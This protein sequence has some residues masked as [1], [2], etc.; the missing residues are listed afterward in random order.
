LY[1]QDARGIHDEELIA[2]VESRLAARLELIIAFT[3]LSHNFL[4]SS[5]PPKPDMIEQLPDGEPSVIRTIDGKIVRIPSRKEYD[6][7]WDEW[8]RRA[9]GRSL[10]GIDLT[11]G[12]RLDDSKYPIQKIFDL[13]AKYETEITDW[14]RN[15][16]LRVLNKLNKARAGGSASK[17]VLAID[18]VVHLAHGQGPLASSLIEDA[19]YDPTEFLNLLDEGELD[20][21][22]LALRRPRGVHVNQ[23]RRRAP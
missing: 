16:V 2:E 13:G 15:E 4:L 7:Y 23:Y 1:Q 21:A 5:K 14:G 22:Q 10:G 3:D 12:L 8:D 6:E 9:A 20:S 18:E 19:P 11:G 17:R